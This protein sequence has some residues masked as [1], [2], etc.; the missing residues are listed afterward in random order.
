MQVRSLHILIESE[1]FVVTVGSWPSQRELNVAGKN[2]A[3]FVQNSAPTATTSW[4][5]FS[6]WVNLQPM[7]Q[8]QPNTC[9]PQPA[10]SSMQTNL[11]F[12]L[13]I[14]YDLSGT[15]AASNDTVPGYFPDVTDVDKVV[16]CSCSQ[17]IILT[18]L[19]SEQMWILDGHRKN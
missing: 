12:A 7:N 17:H 8:F 11:F 9:S 6:D 18:S 2:I 16:R 19:L 3:F 13:T 4:F 10:N 1:V 14:S 5:V 15:V